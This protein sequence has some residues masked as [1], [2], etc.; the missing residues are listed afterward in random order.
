MEPDSAGARVV[1]E[2]GCA[3][4]AR[5]EEL[6]EATRHDEDPQEERQPLII[7]NADDDVLERTSSDSEDISGSEFADFYTAATEGRG[8]RPEAGW[9]D[10]PS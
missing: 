8:G 2:Q 6:G 10:A 5:A 3:S 4:V 7:P 9:F 1:E